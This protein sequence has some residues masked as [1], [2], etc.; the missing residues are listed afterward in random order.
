[1]MISSSQVRSELSKIWPNLR[2]VVLSDSEWWLPSVADVRSLLA[3]LPRLDY[4]ERLYECEE[5]AL[6]LVASQRRAHAADC[7]LGAV[8][9][10]ERFNWPLGI[11]CGTRFRGHDMDHWQNLCLTADGIILIEPQTGQIWP[12][13]PDM[14]Q[15]YFLLM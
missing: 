4:I 15:I 13:Q 2:F 12:P 1:M 14:D 11:V 10:G 7:Q 9:A 5:F 6:E 3:R 8:P